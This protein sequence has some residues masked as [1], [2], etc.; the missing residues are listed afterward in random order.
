MSQKKKN[1]INN[2][3]VHSADVKTAVSMFFLKI[4]SLRLT[5]KF[6]RYRFRLFEGSGNSFLSTV[7]S[8]NVWKHFPHLVGILDMPGKK[9]F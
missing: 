5:P 9:P 8:I 6:Q 7:H 3:I 4:T 1:K 2:G